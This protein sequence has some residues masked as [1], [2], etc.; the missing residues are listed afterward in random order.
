[1]TPVTG[2]FVSDQV[3]YALPGREGWIAAGEEISRGSRRP[4]AVASC[5]LASAPGKQ[6]IRTSLRNPRSRGRGCRGPEQQPIY[7]SCF[8]P[9]PR[10]ITQRNYPVVTE[11][12]EE[13]AR[14]RWPGRRDPSGGG[15][16]H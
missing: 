2:S 8:T 12:S 1:M 3:A 16:G 15:P 13:R 6:K 9:A 14:R 7:Y 5:W 4:L 11:M 10:Q